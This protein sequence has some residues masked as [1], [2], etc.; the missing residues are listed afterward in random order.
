MKTPILPIYLRETYSK[1]LRLI[2]ACHFL[3]SL[4][5]LQP[6]SLRNA[7]LLPGK[8]FGSTCLSGNTVPLSSSRRP[9]APFLFLSFLLRRARSHFPDF[10]PIQSPRSSSA[11]LALLL[12]GGPPSK[13]RVHVEEGVARES[14]FPPYIF[15]LLMSIAT[16]IFMSAVGF[17]KTISRPILS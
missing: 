15:P 12:H 7:P 13:L 17:Y 8:H 16:G 11:A 10:E 4:L 5:G 6:P 14:H 9:G 2:S 1:N 3:M